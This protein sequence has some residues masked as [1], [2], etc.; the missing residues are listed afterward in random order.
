MP[1]L[2]ESTTHSGRITG[3]GSLLAQHAQPYAGPSQIK[4][5]S[6]IQVA[7]KQR[8]MC[9]ASHLLPFTLEN[10]DLGI[11]QIAADDVSDPASVI[12]DLKVAAVLCHDLLEFL[13]SSKCRC[14]GV[15]QV[16]TMIHYVSSNNVSYACVHA[17]MHV[18]TETG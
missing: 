1:A 11:S 18:P 3:V 5:P 8:P 9:N 2:R 12:V 13:Y 4:W 17:C 14:T 16:G 6:N 10:L 15:M 7:A